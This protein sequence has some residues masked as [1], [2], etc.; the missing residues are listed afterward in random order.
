MTKDSSV[1]GKIDDASWAENRVAV[2]ASG[3]L[4]VS[5]AASCAFDRS[6]HY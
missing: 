4:I 5:T 6:S 2:T 3:E 1:N